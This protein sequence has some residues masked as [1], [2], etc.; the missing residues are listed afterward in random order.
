[1]LERILK[2]EF[3]RNLFKQ[4]QEYRSKQNQNLVEEV[5]WC[6]GYINLLQLLCSYRIYLFV[7]CLAATLC[8]ICLREWYLNVK[9]NGIHLCKCCKKKAH[10]NLRN[11]L[12]IFLPVVETSSQ[13]NKRCLFFISTFSRIIQTIFHESK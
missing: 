5:N 6:W 10:I 3:L 4:I 1:M 7:W 9:L 13:T 2:I 11:F 8:G 12:Q